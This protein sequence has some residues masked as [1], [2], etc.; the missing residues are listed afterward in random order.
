VEDLPPLA[1][2][3]PGPEIMDAL[4]Q[5]LRHDGGSTTSDPGA[6]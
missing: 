5:S 3:V 1:Q 6:G 4:E 2:F